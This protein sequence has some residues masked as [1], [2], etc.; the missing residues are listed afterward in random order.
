MAA[1]SSIGASSMDRWSKCPGSVRLSAGIPGR[2]SVY[3]QEGTLAH[4][5]ADICIKRRGGP[6]IKEIIEYD[7][8]GEHKLATVPADMVDAVKVF[9]DHA[10]AYVGAGFEVWTEQRFDLSSIYPG[11]FGTSDLVA[12]DP[13]TKTLFVDD[14]KHGQGIPVD[15]VGNAQI[16]YYG[17]GALMQFG[18]PVEKIRLGICQPRCFHPDGPLRFETLTAMDL[19]DWMADLREYAA[20]TDVPDAPLVD[21][22][23]CRFCPAAAVCPKLKSNAQE[24]AKLVFNDQPNSIDVTELEQALDMLP[25]LE[26]W[27]SNVRELSYEMAAQGKAAFSRHK[28]V[29]KRAT[30]KFNADVTCVRLAEAFGIPAT[31]FLSEPE[32]KS[33]AQ[34][35]KLLPGKNDKERRALLAPYT[36]KESS[37]HTLVSNDD[38]RP[39]VALDAKSAFIE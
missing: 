7:D 12:Y 10:M 35:A 15:A 31:H 27:I 8:H 20:A 2:S 37:G 24:T 6:L 18:M 38:P 14:Y 33:V 17:V 39:A 1:H 29:A 11:L 30:E 4:A 9:Y 21:G 5:Y 28:L 34:V 16:R 19:L 26:A 36:S 25:G 22:D 13:V 23:H 32:M 3:A